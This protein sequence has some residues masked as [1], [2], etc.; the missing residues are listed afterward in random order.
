MVKEYGWSNQSSVLI[1]VFALAMFALSSVLGSLVVARLGAP[2]TLLLGIA[3]ASAGIFILTFAQA[4][5]VLAYVGILVGA[6]GAFATPAFLTV[7][8]SLALASDQGRL[9]GALN[10]VL[11]LSAGIGS[12]VLSAVFSGVKESSFGAGLPFLLG[13]LSILA[14]WFVT[15][16][17]LRLPTVLPHNPD[18]GLLAAID[19][20]HVIGAM[21]DQ[22]PGAGGGVELVPMAPDAGQRDESRGGSEAAGESKPVLVEALA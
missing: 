13:A 18:A 15:W 20:S 12:A 11:L 22:S 2:N 21:R 10:S 1:F 9:Q 19:G 17:A 6:S 5:P 16:Y 3:L 7:I 4:T 8:S 14:S